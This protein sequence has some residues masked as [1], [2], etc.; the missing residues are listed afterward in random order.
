VAEL[1]ELNLLCKI[2]RQFFDR[3]FRVWSRFVQFRFLIFVFSA[4][5]YTQWSILAR[6]APPAI[7]RGPRLL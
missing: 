4:H 6:G 7:Q 3:P 2:F 1:I 5:P